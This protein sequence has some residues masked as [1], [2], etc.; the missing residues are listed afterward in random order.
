MQTLDHAQLENI[1]IKDFFNSGVV[2]SV[3]NSIKWLRQFGLLSSSR[4]CPTC[5]KMMTEMPQ[6]S[7]KDG[8]AWR[9]K[10]RSC[11]TTSSIRKDSFFAKSNLALTDCITLIFFWA[12]DY[13]SVAQ[14]ATELNL[15]IR[16]ALDW[17]GFVR[18]ICSIELVG[19]MIGGPGHIVA[20]D[21]ALRSPGYRHSI[22]ACEEWVFGG[23][24]TTT[25]EYFMVMVDNR[26]ADTILP[27]ISKNIKRGTEIEW[28]D[29]GNIPA[30]ANSHPATLRSAFRR[31]TNELIGIYPDFG[32]NNISPKLKRPR[33]TTTR[34][35]LIEKY[36]KQCEL[37][38]AEK[39]GA[40]REFIPSFLEEFMW[41]KQH[42]K[43]NHFSEIIRAI[44]ILYPQYYAEETVVSSH[45]EE[46]AANVVVADQE[47][48]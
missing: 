23:V 20:L 35:N 25:N 10:G 14:I 26:D 6:K 15:T 40:N 12:K 29:E 9:C 47:S 42:P 45:S 21:F 32:L 37:Q 4:A 43:K 19:R 11:R 13:M 38:F 39:N 36:W 28:R 16:T 1:S 41:R 31:P 24:D 33:K 17:C 30:S 27:I 22:A 8:V 18:E 46:I 7:T 34:K 48:S 44:S 2:S 5:G 3:T